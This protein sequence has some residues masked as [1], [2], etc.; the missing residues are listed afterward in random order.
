MTKTPK[1]KKFYKLFIKFNNIMS[2]SSFIMGVCKDL[3]L[4]DHISIHWMLLKLCYVTNY[5]MEFKLD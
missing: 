1:K 2:H 4:C 3:I 5:V